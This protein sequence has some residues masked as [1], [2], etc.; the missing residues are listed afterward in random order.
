MKIIEKVGV[1]Q[2]F[3]QLK[4]TVSTRGGFIKNSGDEKPINIKK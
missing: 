2:T 4:K 1:H 3:M